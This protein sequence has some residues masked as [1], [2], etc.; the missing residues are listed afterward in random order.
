[1]YALIEGLYPLCRSITGNG[2]RKTLRKVQELLPIE[3]HEVA[4][5][6]Q[7]FD[8][9]VPEEWNIR[10][11]W[12]ATLDGRRVV[13]FQD[14]NLHVVGYSV[15]VRERFPVEE[16]KRHLHVLEDHPDW[17]PYRTSYY[18]RDWGFCLTKWQY[19]ALVEPEYEVSIDTS[20]TAGAL[21]YGELKLPGRVSD[22]IVI[23]AHVCHPSMCND[24]LSGIA[25]ATFLGRELSTWDRRFSYRLLFIPGTIGSLT[26]LATH[27]DDSL[28]IRGGLSLVCL[29]DARP[30]TYKKSLAGD[31]PVDRAATRVLHD[32]GREETV[33]DFFPFGYDERQFNAPG[34]RIPF[35]SLMRG[36]HDR[37]PEYHTSADD[38][39]FI[40]AAQ[41]DDALDACLA[42]LSRLETDAMFQNLAP[43]GE[44]QLGRRG[45]YRAMG[46]GGDPD[47]LSTAMFWVLALSDGSWSLTDIAE[48]AELPLATIERAADVL[49]GQQLLR[50]I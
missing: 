19:D 38:L 14:S 42:M 21:T 22:E 16:L 32:R 49:A 43:Y 12:I 17:I 1:M 24:N 4:S 33:I 34:F 8:W 35:G 46:G 25:V 11:A 40:S 29:G 39:S 48:R 30:L 47:D 44:P 37:F 41:L 36:R 50:K 31:G 5:G 27:R 20:L 7:V 10:D 18:H 3:I 6:T 15:P 23:S 2:V 28:N 9:T 13:D 26:W 45:V